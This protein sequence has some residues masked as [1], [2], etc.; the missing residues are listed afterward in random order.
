MEPADV[1]IGELTSHVQAV[2]SQGLHDPATLLALARA[3]APLLRELL[4]HESRV[5]RE[6][7]M[8]D[9]PLD[10]IERGST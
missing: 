4:A 1:R 5:Q 8:H 10:R 6:L 2:D 3:V 9:S 7:S